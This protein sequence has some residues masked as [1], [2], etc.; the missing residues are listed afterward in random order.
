M[1]NNAAEPMRSLDTLLGQFLI[2]MPNMGDTRFEK[3]VIF[4]CAHSGDGAMGFVIN[5]TLETPALPEFLHQLNLIS[6]I[7]RDRMPHPLRETPLHSGGPVEPGRGFVLHSSDY[8]SQSTL[9]IVEGVSLTATLEILR[10]IAT[11]EGPERS[12]IALGYSGWASGQIEDEIGANGWLTCPATAD[13][14]FDGIQETKYER[15]LWSMGINPVLL[16]GE[17]GHA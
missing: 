14:V 9:P 12:M 5:R 16:S 3:T 8:S 1:M 11:G 4:L 10:A 2:A 6:D 7:E 17:S 15:A 13:L